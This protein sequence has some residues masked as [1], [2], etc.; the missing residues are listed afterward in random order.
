MF[1]QNE[2]QLRDR[3]HSL[4]CYW[5]QFPLYEYEGIRLGNF[6]D[7]NSPRMMRG[8]W[9]RCPHACLQDWIL[10]SPSVISMTKSEQAQLFGMS[11]GKRTMVAALGHALTAAGVPSWTY[12]H[13]GLSQQE[14]AGIDVYVQQLNPELLDTYGESAHWIVNADQPWG[15]RRI[16]TAELWYECPVWVSAGQRDTGFS[17]LDNRGEVIDGMAKDDFVEEVSKAMGRYFDGAEYLVK[18][19]LELWSKPDLL[20]S[21]PAYRAAMLQVARAFRGQPSLDR[22]R[23]IEVFHRIYNSILGLD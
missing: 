1:K 3:D 22:A 5:S 7:I 2:Q 15:V 6:K 11:S 21:D 17:R 20:F 9:S 4:Q 23:V 8:L 10:A 16:R 19:L 13:S 12:I 14:F 18:L